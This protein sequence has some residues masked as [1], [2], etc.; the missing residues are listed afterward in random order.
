M[1]GGSYWLSLQKE[2]ATNELPAVNS[3]TPT[4]GFIP[5]QDNDNDGLPDWQDTLNIH[6]I[7]LSLPP[8]AT[9]KTS[10]LAAELA[11]QMTIPGSNAQSIMAEV[12]PDLAQASIDDP[13]ELDDI[14]VSSDNS[15]LALRQYG[16]RVAAVAINNAPP[17]GTED[18]LTILN[19]AFTRNDPAVL[20]GLDPTIASYEKM[21]K[22]MLATSVPS[23]LATE[24]LALINTYQALTNDIKSFREVFSDALPAMLRFRRYSADAESLYVAI[25]SIYLKLDRNGIQW[26]NADIASRFITIDKYEND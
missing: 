3:P 18:E 12:G 9:T 15:L 7:D 20:R 10:E 21:L 11:A 2:E 16:N 4:R 5:V 17:V 13:Y 19:R 25:S 24:H 22:E 1:V 6:T 14:V 26:S 8:S 23:S